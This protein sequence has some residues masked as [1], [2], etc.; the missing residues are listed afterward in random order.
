MKTPRAAIYT[1]S[2]LKEDAVCTEVFG[3][4]SLLYNEKPGFPRRISVGYPPE[5][6]PNHFL[7]NLAEQYSVVLKPATGTM[8]V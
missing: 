6:N 7:F 5:M 8:Y 4:R 3:S 2:A 1:C